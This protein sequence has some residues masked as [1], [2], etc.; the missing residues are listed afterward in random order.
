[1]TGSGAILIVE[2]DVLVRHALAEYLRDC[3]YKVAEAVDADEAR[4][5]LV[6]GTGGIEIVMVHAISQTDRGYTLTNWVR[7]KFPDVQ[8]II[9]GSLATATEQAGSLCEKG[10][11]LTKPYDHKLILAHIRRLQAAR[12]RSKG[13]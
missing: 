1:M 3:G 13:E 12:D 10:P 7:A 8:I 9:A 4:Q 2:D 5:L 6:K 11:A